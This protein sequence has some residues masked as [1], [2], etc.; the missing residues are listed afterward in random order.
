M[1]SYVINI[2]HLKIAAVL[3]TLHWSAGLAAQADWLQLAGTTDSELDRKLMQASAENEAQQ[4]LL[5]EVQQIVEARSL[6]QV[7]DYYQP[8]SNAVEFTTTRTH[9]GADV[10]V[11]YPIVLPDRLVHLVWMDTGMTTFEVSVTA[12][13]LARAAI[14]L[15]DEMQIV[16]SSFG[17]MERLS[18]Q[19]FNWLISP[20]RDSL[21]DADISNLV[22]LSTPELRVI[23]LAT[24]YDGRRYLMEDFSVTMSIAPSQFTQEVVALDGKVLL[25]GIS[26]ATDNLGARAGV[27]S[28]L[29]S[30]SEL[31]GED[32]FLNQRFT[33]DFVEDQLESEKLDVLHLATQV[34]M[35]D[36][37]ETSL[38]QT[39]DD[40]IPLSVLASWLSNRKS[41]V[42]FLVLS[43][44]RTQR[45]SQQSALGLMGL[46][47][48]AGSR[49]TLAG[50]WRTNH[51]ATAALMTIFYT[52]LVAGEY[53]EVAL[54]EAQLEMLRS[55]RFSHPSY[56]GGFQL[57]T[58]GN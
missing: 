47:Y 36:G 8:Q 2:P 17:G 49:Y 55:P 22:F 43:N 26:E 21:R 54:R 48:I 5:V 40:S 41:P 12:D 57:F 42:E 44:S 1:D 9:M 53:P 34:E 37:L 27:E 46:G 19:L 15:R 18:S 56:W 14:N 10:A 4:S 13:Q 32:F 35:E 7:L 23:P 29:A 31:V 28:E 16:G 11:I 58:H 39:Y 45:R 52:E 33:A 51:T 20:Y 6:A 38:L 3:I 25:A 24:L 50:L 30:I